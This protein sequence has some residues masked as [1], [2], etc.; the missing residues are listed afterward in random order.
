MFKIAVTITT[1]IAGAAV[2][3]IFVAPGLRDGD[4]HIVEGY[5]FSHGSALGV[6]MSITKERQGGFTEVIGTK[7][8]EF[9]VH[10]N[11]IFVTQRPV[12]STGTVDQTTNA[13][14]YYRID[15]ANHKVSGPFTFSDVKTQAEWNFLKQRRPPADWGPTICKFD[16]FVGA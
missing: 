6:Q 5:Y 15:M 11:A 9:I 3:A 12:K 8:E 4:E 13:C 14:L 1:L 7:V 2:V 16:S 10:D